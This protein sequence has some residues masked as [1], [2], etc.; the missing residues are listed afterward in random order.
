MKVSLK[1]ISDQKLLRG[2]DELVVKSHLNEAELLAYIAEVDHRRLYLEQGCPSMYCYCTEVLHFSEARARHRIHAARAARTYPAV[3]ERLRKGELHVAGL[4][5]LAPV[6]TPENHEELLDLAR[7]KSKRAIEALLADR[8]PKPDVPPRVR[9]L[10]E[11]RQVSAGRMPSEIAGS[12][13][14]TRTR[15]FGSAPS[16]QVPRRAQNPDPSPLGGKRFKIQF[17]ASQALCDKLREAQ[18]LLRHQVPCGDLSEIFGRALT[19]LVEDTKRKKFALTSRPR[20][21]SGASRK[22]GTASRHI[23]AEIKRAVF[24]RDEGRCAFAGR[25]DR[26]CASRDFLE[27]HHLDP[28]AR[29]KRHSIERIE[30]RCRGHNHYAAMLDYGSEHMARSRGKT[31]SP[32]GRST[33]TRPSDRG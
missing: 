1:T 29:S 26:R 12:T 31:T 14:G 28:W 13:L 18:A 25:N 33:S 4:S 8:A 16:G 3:F 21:R 10:P 17:T 19:L 23:P 9:Q 30:L 20:T 6:L 2:L 7:H 15:S 11:R 24:E 22:A 27:Y 5:L 32:G